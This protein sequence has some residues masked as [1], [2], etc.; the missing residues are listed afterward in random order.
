MK[1]SLT[2]HNKTY[3]VESDEGYFPEEDK[4]EYIEYE[5]DDEG[6]VSEKK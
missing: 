5:F 3:S 1:L 4:Q 6:E 2:L